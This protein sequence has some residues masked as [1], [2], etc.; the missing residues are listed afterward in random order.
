M[1]AGELRHR[2]TIQQATE[3]PSTSG[4][5]T[6]TWSTVATVWAAIEALSGREAFAAQ[7]VNAQVSSRIR[8][9]YRAGITPKMRIV[10]GARTFNI[11]SV[12]DMESRRRE[13]QL[14]VSEVV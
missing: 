12:M 9:R 1:R 3:T 10:F 6:Q 8:I 7:Q 14:L 2:I 13:L 11:E 5:I 4:A